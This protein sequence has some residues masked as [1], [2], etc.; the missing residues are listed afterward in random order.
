MAKMGIL[1]VPRVVGKE[2]YQIEDI[3]AFLLAG[4]D[5]EMAAKE[6]CRKL[7]EAVAANS[8]Q[9]AKFF[10]FINNQENYHIALMKDALAHY[11]SDKNV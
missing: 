4:I 9:L 2:L 1:G 3:E 7:S 10:D 11:R 5:E 8:P 6:E